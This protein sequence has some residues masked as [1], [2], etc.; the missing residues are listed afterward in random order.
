V[1]DERIIEYLR[2]RGR[3]HVPAGFV[4]SVMTAVDAAPVGR[5]AFSWF[6]PAAAAAGVVAVVVVLALVLGPG[7]D[8]GPAP[9]PSATPSAGATVEELRAVVTGATER[10]AES[11]GVQ[12]VQ[13]GWIEEYLASATWFDWRPNGDQVVVT[14]SDIDVQA[15]WWA[16]PEGEPLSIGERIQTEMD[17]IVDGSWYWTEA[18]SWG[19]PDDR[20]PP[21][22]P[23]TYGIGLL[24]GEIPALPPTVDAAETDATRRNLD[25]GGQVW[26]LEGS[27]EGGTWVSEWHIGPDGA[28]VSWAFEGVGVTMYP[29]ED[30]G[31]ASRRFVIEFTSIDEPDP[32]EAPES[33]T[34]DPAEYGLPADFPLEPG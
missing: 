1:N 23:L 18:G 22:G 25:D 3:T 32:I 9:S 31:T 2:A 10:L 27:E 8:V 5:A 24:T 17:V 11:A 26:V 12:G 6:L 4:G 19:L 30:F 28:L 16:D 13:T 33:P 15:P 29:S 7:R 34:P 14:R 21:R 20:T